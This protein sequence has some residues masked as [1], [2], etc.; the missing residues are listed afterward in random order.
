MACT[1]RSS[2]GPTRDLG[3]HAAAGVGTDPEAAARSQTH[4]APDDNPHR[5]PCGW[6]RTKS[7]AMHGLLSLRPVPPRCPSA[8]PMLF[9]RT[10]YADTT[11]LA[12]AGLASEPKRLLD[13]L[14]GKGCCGRGGLAPQGRLTGVEV[15]ALLGAIGNE[16]PTQPGLGSRVAAGASPD[17]GGRVDLPES[18]GRRVLTLA[19]SRVGRATRMST[20]KRHATSRGDAMGTPGTPGTAPLRARVV[21][22]PG[23]PPVGLAFLGPFR[24]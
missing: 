12:T 19:R 4:R 1:D 14:R 23:S 18:T 20:T 16:V 8:S 10:A 5:T 15:A 17:A 2:R 7:L 11:D 13:S 3:T 6:L 24:H 9:Q 22:S 21:K